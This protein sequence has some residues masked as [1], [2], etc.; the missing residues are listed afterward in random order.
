M[1]HLFDLLKRVG[2]L[3]SP[4]GQ[5]RQRVSVLLDDL[6]EGLVNLESIQLPE[7]A[8]PPPAEPNAGSVFTM[9]VN[10]VTELFYREDSGSGGTV[11]QLTREGDTF[12]LVTV[13][14]SMTWAEVMS[15]VNANAYERPV[16]FEAG[17]YT[18]DAAIPISNGAHVVMGPGVTLNSTQGIVGFSTFIFFKFGAVS[19]GGTLA[20]TPT[21]GT[22][23]ISSTVSFAV[24]T[25]IMIGQTAA[26]V[27]DFLAAQY[28]V[29]GV[30]GGGPFTITLDRALRLPFVSGDNVRAYTTQPR[31][32]T[33]EGNGATMTGSASRAVEFTHGLNVHVRGLQFDDAANFGAGVSHDIGSL[34]CTVIDCYSNSGCAFGF[35]LE[36]AERCS[37]VRC[38]SDVGSNAITLFDCA[39]CSVED[40]GGSRNTN[41][42]VQLTSNLM[43]VGCFGCVVRGGFGTRGG[44][45]GL[46]IDRATDCLIEGFK[47][48]GNVD[49]IDTGVNGV[50]NKFVGC[51]TARNTAAGVRARSTAGVVIA[52]HTSLGDLRAVIALNSLDLVN[53]DLIDYTGTGVLIDA[54]IASG[55]R[56]NVTGA[57]INSSVSGS[58]GCDINGAGSPTVRFDG[59]HFVNNSA[60]ANQ[61]AILH[62]TGATP[63]VVIVKD[64]TGAQ[65][66]ASNGYAGQAGATLRVEGRTDFASFTVPFT[67]NAAGFA[68][69]NTL[70]ANGAGTAQ[71]VSWTDLKV[72]DHVNWTR[73][74]NGG[75]PG[76]MPLTVSTPGTGFSATFAVGDTSTYEYRVE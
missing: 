9:D 1:G 41:S 57:R 64:C 22:A 13:D 25:R 63:G 58:I 73:I 75:T 15:V 30:A 20:A 66:S 21:V 37:I 28:E 51:M 4:T 52:E 70:V 3:S 11:I 14:P 71:A 68:N 49:G 6:I 17:T 34:N 10:G 35:M 76:V 62:R 45:I 47:A 53:A 55:S 39:D 26:T 31:D 19:A 24:G 23:T 38:S 40:S 44:N 59:T 56:V 33:I 50:R 74:V 60:A 72:R 36:S 67:I 61:T 27:H 69:V 18:V 29:K 46:I 2:D 5:W 16:F 42:G 54:A 32:I 7:Q 12:G 48:D 43:T 65:A 8:V